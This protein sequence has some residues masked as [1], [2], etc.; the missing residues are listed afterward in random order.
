MSKILK[1]FIATISALIISGCQGGSPSTS[2]LP[3]WY[4]NPP[5]SNP[6]VFHGVGE[7]S[8]KEASRA[9]ALAV[10]GGQISTEVSSS[11]DMSTD[12][13]NDEVSK[14]VREHTKTT[15]E[16]IKFVGVKELEVKHNGGVFYTH[17]T[18]NRDTLL[19]AQK[20]KVDVEYNKLNS[21][22]ERA[23]AGNVFELIQNK[24]AIDKSVTKDRKTHV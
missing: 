6:L 13:H 11:L 9:N 23:K 2:E 4:L 1:A 8:T 20:K 16:T 12:V 21:L 18:V 15:I 5:P 14:N 10:I 22:Y 19:Q 3:D 24:S 17:L 7:A